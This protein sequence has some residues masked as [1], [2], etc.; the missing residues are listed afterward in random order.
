ML[1]T[2]IGGGSVRIDV[3]YLSKFDEGLIGKSFVLAKSEEG[4]DANSMTLRNPT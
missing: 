1:A 4:Y 3:S 2:E